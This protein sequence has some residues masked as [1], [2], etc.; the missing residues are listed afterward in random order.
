MSELSVE[1]EAEYADAVLHAGVQIWASMHRCKGNPCME[2]RSNGYG[3]L[4]EVRT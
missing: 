4:A 1:Y 3:Y 2:W